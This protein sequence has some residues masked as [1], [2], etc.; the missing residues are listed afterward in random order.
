MFS[1]K[2]ALKNFAKFIEENLWWKLIFI[3]LKNVV[4]VTNKK[5]EAKRN[6]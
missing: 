5:K 6:F 1:E 4:E 3:K 2:A